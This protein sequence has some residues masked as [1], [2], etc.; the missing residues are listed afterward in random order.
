[1][2]FRLFQSRL[3]KQF[4]LL[5]PVET[6]SDQQKRITV[7]Q[8]KL[9]MNPMIVPPAIKDEP[10][11]GRSVEG[12]ARIPVLVVLLRE[13]ESSL[14]EIDGGT[15]RSERIV[16]PLKGHPVGVIEDGAPPTGGVGEQRRAR[17]FVDRHL[18][19]LPD[20]IERRERSAPAYSISVTPA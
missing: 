12:E 9:H 5:Y 14:W 2:I 18:A 11:L 10:I 8:L 15:I 7:S 1:M 4:K 16:Q 13:G 6:S 3:R 19:H 20:A 17:L